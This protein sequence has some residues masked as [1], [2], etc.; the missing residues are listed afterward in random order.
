MSIC[1]TEERTHLFGMFN[2]LESFGIEKP[3]SVNITFENATNGTPSYDNLPFISKTFTKMTGFWVQSSIIAVFTIFCVFVWIA[4][5]IADEFKNQMENSLPKFKDEPLILENW[6]DKI[7]YFN[8]FVDGINDFFG[9]MLALHLFHV[10][11]YSSRVSTISLFTLIG[12]HQN[13]LLP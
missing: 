9:V 12:P 5:L 11:L 7:E 2:I 8:R 6:W 13:T 1:L 10:F 4:S 3:T